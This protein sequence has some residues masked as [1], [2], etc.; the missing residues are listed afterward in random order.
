MKRLWGGHPVRGAVIAMLVCLFMGMAAS[1][2]LDAVQDVE[3]RRYLH[4]RDNGDA[5]REL[6]AVARMELNAAALAAHLAGTTS[7]EAALAGHEASLAESLVRLRQALMVLCRGGKYVRYAGERVGAVVQEIEYWPEDG[8]DAQTTALA[9][10]VDGISDRASRL[11]RE[12]GPQIQSRPVTA[13]AERGC[14]AE[15]F[16]RA[17]TLAEG[18]YLD[19][20]A[21]GRHELDHHHERYRSLQRAVLGGGLV[22]AVLAAGLG[23][24]ALAGT[25]RLLDNRKEDA[26]NVVE[27]RAGMDRILEALPVGIVLVGHDDAIRRV[28]LAATNLLGIGFDWLEERQTRWNMFC[29]MSSARFADAPRRVEIESEVRLRRLDGG[30]IDA[31]KSS[32]PVMLGG[33]TLTLEVFADI[34]TRKRAE[35][36]LEQEK[37]RLESVLAGIDEGVAL[38][39]DAGRILEINA[40]LIRILGCS[41]A[42]VTG[43]PIYSLFSDDRF[44]AAVRGGLDSLRENPRNKVRELQLEAFRDMDVIVRMQAV[45]EGDRFAGMIVSVIE[46]TEIIEAK[47]RVE[48]AS[49]AKTMFLANVS[50]EIRTP[51]NA[52]IGLGEVLSRLELGVEQTECLDGIRVCADNLLAIIN[53]ILDFSKI[54]AGMFKVVAEDTSLPVLLD[55]VAAMFMEQARNKGLGFAV[56]TTTVPK[57]VRVD[58]VRLTQILV[59]LVGNALKFTAAGEV[60]LAVRGRAVGDGCRVS[61]VVHD[62]GMGIEAK[63]QERVFSS[64]EQADGSLTRQYGGTGLGLTIA[65]GLVRLMGGAGIA[66]CSAPDDGSAFSFVL[67]M[68]VPRPRAALVAPD[69]D[70]SAMPDFSRIR[71]LAAEDNPFNQALFRK[72]LAGLGV[73]RIE[74]VGNGQAA[75]DLLATDAAF[76]IIF[77]D[78]QMPVLDGLEAAKAIRAMGLSIPIIALTAHVLDADHLRSMDAGM[79]GH[80][81]KPYKT[82]DL[83]DALRT[84]CV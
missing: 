6:L 5:Y 81:L 60:V 62:T 30:Y 56:V 12:R 82:Q 73:T 66:L 21:Q 47:R 22:F 54:E 39:D 69:A 63:R 84:W 9:L 76:D 75:L 10:V 55:K 49:R 80:L 40:C 68:D 45:V 78:I 7:D 37:Q 43:A 71:V 8:S 79:N 28:N 20:V 52:I 31:V 53:D 33:E 74:I 61:F 59:N 70:R 67:D 19:A 38:T 27:A 15:L 72:M 14:C 23:W 46:V 25:R 58:G 13:E 1:L 51:L 77:M 3:R 32:I 29:P 18:L 34:T 42:D 83:V 50:H 57:L 2:A 48:A 17:R 26:A 64:F 4:V 44:Q 41:N 65:H 24:S 36:A 16:A 35:R 11:V